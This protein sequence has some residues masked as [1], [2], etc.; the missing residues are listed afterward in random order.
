MNQ[1]K[2]ILTPE[3]YH[4]YFTLNEFFDGNCLKILLSKLTGLAVMIAAFPAKVP[5]IVKIYENKSGE[6]I[7]LPSVT[8]ELVA[9]A[10]YMSY[11]YSKDYPFHQ[12]GEV[13]FLMIQTLAIAVL[14]LYYA[15]ATE[16]AAAY[17]VLYSTYC[18]IMMEVVPTELL[19]TMQSLNILVFT[20]AKGLQI[21]TNYE[22]GHTGQ[23]SEITLG[24]L[25]TGSLGR[26]FTSIQ[27]TGDFIVILANL[28]S[29]AANAILI[30]QIWYYWDVTKEKFD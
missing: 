29:C 7:S 24:L 8:L 22:N 11:S 6:G 20:V 13:L 26:I 10:V 14:C 9:Y 27:E 3:C 18:V 21:H 25:F 30:G 15:G 28:L 12:W 1:I 23:L 2:N 19:W 16:L 5:Q 4:K 17:A